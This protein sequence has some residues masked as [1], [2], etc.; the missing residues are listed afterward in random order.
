[1]SPERAA[2]LLESYVDE[3]DLVGDD[4][5]SRLFTAAFR[6]FVHRARQGLHPFAGDVTATDVVIAATAMLRQQNLEVFELALWQ[7]FGGQP[8]V[9][10]DGRE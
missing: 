2:E 6:L 8:W 1:M 4:E 10:A 5:V 7:S 9:G 3:P